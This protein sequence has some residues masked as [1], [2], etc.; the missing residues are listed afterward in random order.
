MKKLLFIIFTF[1]C[2]CSCNNDLNTSQISQSSNATLSDSSSSFTTSNTT[3][4]SI[5][6]SSSESLSETTPSSSSSSS[7]QTEIEIEFP[8]IN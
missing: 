7:R 4:E 5:I 1:L 3:E 8:D 6:T 2:V